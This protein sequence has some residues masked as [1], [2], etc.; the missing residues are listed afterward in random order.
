MNE[1]A[2][3]LNAK[4]LFMMG[5]QKWKD[6]RSKLVPTF[7]SGKMKAMFPLILECAEEFDKHL[8]KMADANEIFEAKVF[9]KH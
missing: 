9:L 2:D 4:N 5:G 8:E 6:M 7:T 3:P 1:E